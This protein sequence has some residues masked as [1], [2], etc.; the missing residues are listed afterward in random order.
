M[1]LLPTDKSSRIGWCGCWT[2]QVAF[3]HIRCANSITTQRELCDTIKGMINVAA[4]TRSTK[5]KFTE[6][7]F[8]LQVPANTNALI[9]LVI[10][11]NH[12][13]T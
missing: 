10:A 6:R 4:V 12:V 11:L 7:L 1:A 9:M 5:T 8:H 13:P 2:L 3:C